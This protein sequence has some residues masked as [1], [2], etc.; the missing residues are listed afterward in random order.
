MIRQTAKIF[1]ILPAFLA[2]LA[3]LAFAPPAAETPAPA[4]GR[5]RAVSVL[6][7]LCAALAAGAALEQSSRFSPRL[8]RIPAPATAYVAAMADADYLIE[9]KEKGGRTVTS[10]RPLDESDR[11]REI[12]R[13]NVGAD[14]TDLALSSAG[15]MLEACRARQ[16][17]LLAEK[18][19]P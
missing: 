16:K 18:G 5:R 8:C 3:A 10:V 7:A 1:C 19:R 14:T 17:M 9:K 4:A 12:A 11:M 13:I 6:G 2:F 15:Q